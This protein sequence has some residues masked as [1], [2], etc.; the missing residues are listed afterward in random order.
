VDTDRIRDEYV[1][2]KK[3][4]TTSMKS[5][6]GDEFNPFE[7]LKEGFTVSGKKSSSADKSFVKRPV[8][9]KPSVRRMDPLKL[10]MSEY[11]KGKRPLAWKKMSELLELYTAGNEE[12]VLAW[13]LLGLAEAENGSMDSASRAFQKASALDR[14]DAESLNAL[15]WF[16]L[17]EGKT[18][19]AVNRLLD[20]LYIDEKNAGFKSNLER[21]RGARDVKMLARMEKPSSFIFVTL[22]RRSIFD[23]VLEAAGGMLAGP[24][25]KAAL[26]GAGIVLLAVLGWVFYPLAVNFVRN[27]NFTS[28]IGKN[29]IRKVSIQDVE[30]LVQ[31][32]QNYSV[33]LSEDDVKRKFSQVKSFMA[34]RQF[35]RAR[36]LINEL[37]NS[38]AGEGVKTQVDILQS[39]LPDTDPD[40]IDFIPQARDVIRLPFLYK[41]VLIRWDGM[42]A[43][44]DH[45]DQKETSFD[46]LI[47]FVDEGVVEGIADCRLDGFQQLRNKD[48]VSVTGKIT[49]ITLDNR[50]VVIGKTFKP[51][52]K[53]E[54]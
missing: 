23:S 17:L 10:A 4:G 14:N 44:I 43:N 47:N 30:Q 16:D 21:I 25:G 11:R 48:K 24:F 35:N 7:A 49:G 28:E 41:D 40:A 18:D 9:E 27:A 22:P 37:L 45:R 2:S 26:I 6:S 36:I 46:L 34:Q 5:A 54:K 53:E 29:P 51:I 33:R 1:P 32:R 8:R 31:E 50:V 42:V 38:N 12:N 19:A 39:L 20:A 3:R 52:G 15:A 13:K